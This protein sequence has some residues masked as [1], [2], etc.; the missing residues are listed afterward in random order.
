MSYLGW[1]EVRLFLRHGSTVN[2]LIPHG[3]SAVLN[4]IIALVIYVMFKAL[5]QDSLWTLQRLRGDVVTY[6]LHHTE[7]RDVV[8]AMRRNPPPEAEVETKE[9]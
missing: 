1:Y 3:L 8:T 2:E 9:L 4:G 7:L 6:A 5:R